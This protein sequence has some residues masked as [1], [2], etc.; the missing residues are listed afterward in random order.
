MA[1]NVKVIAGDPSQGRTKSS[2]FEHPYAL[3]PTPS[4]PTDGSKPHGALLNAVEMFLVHNILIRAINSILYHA[5]LVKLHDDIKDFLHFC[6]V[7]V[8]FTNLHHDSEEEHIFPEWARACGQPDI[9]NE[10]VAEHTT[11]HA[12]LQELRNY[13]K[14]T[15]DDTTRHSSEEV[16]RIIDSFA[17]ALTTHLRNEI[18][19]VL[20]MQQ[21]PNGDEQRK[22]FAK[23]VEKGAAQADNTT[24]IPF[25]LGCH[26]AGFEGGKHRFPS[27]PWFVIMGVVWWYG[28]THKATWRFCLAICIVGQRRRSFEIVVSEHTRR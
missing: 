12:G 5:P 3:I 1:T 9:M 24:Q 19:T 2:P 17:P 8:D 10:N 26:D 16:I 20:Q 15:R 11:F 13:A 4:L 18:P 14:Q 27:L 25:A 7:F 21:Y 23:G 22:I 28:G 6:E